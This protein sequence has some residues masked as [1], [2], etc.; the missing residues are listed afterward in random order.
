MSET[1]QNSGLTRRQF[2][3]GVGRG[4]GLLAL[5]G[6]GGLLASRWAGADV[7]WQIDPFACVRCRRCSTEC[8][9]EESAVKVV[10]DFNM[11]GYCRL[12]FGF[13]QTNP[14][15]LDEGA[16]NQMCPTGAIQRRYVEDPYFQYTIDRDLCNGC[17]KCVQGCNK[18]GNGSLYVQVLHDRCENCNECAIA[19]A[20]PADAFIRVPAD[21]PYVM[22]HKGPEGVRELTERV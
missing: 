4:A 3:S 11:C 10:H 22:K 8:V 7:L 14:V 18:F 19:E 17:A 1:V 15:E 5:G 2:F 21:T 16:E 12:C 20:C 9:L 13:F 6:I